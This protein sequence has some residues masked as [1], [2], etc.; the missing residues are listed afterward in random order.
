MSIDYSNIQQ[1]T[2]QM[3]TR[4]RNY[5]HFHLHI[6]TR[7]SLAFYEMAQVLTIMKAK[8]PILSAAMIALPHRVK[9]DS[10]MN[11]EHIIREIVE[12]FVDAATDQKRESDTKSLPSSTIVQILGELDRLQDMVHAMPYEIDILDPYWFKVGRDSLFGSETPTLLAYTITEGKEA[13]FEKYKG[14]LDDLQ[15]RGLIY[16]KPGTIKFTRLGSFVKYSKIFSYIQKTYPQ[17]FKVERKYVQPSGDIRKYRRGDRYT[18]LHV[19]RTLRNIVKK[20]KSTH[21]IMNEDLRMRELS[22]EKRCLV[23]LAIDHSWSMARSKKLHYAKEAVAGLVF[24]AKNNRDQTALI[25]F[26]DRARILSLPSKQYGQLLEKLTH[27]RPE[28]ET[29]I[30]DTLVK[31][32]KIMSSSTGNTLKHLIILTDGIPTSEI[33][34]VT[35]N[36]LESQILCESRKLKK[37]GV[38]ISV[39]C[40]RDEFEENDHSLAGKI[41]SIGKGTLSLMRTQDLLNQM[42]RGYANVKSGSI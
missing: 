28:N 25:A 6:G 22:K 11:H 20:R 33:D 24:A 23:L 12:S 15:Q 29:N 3:M 31:S 9:S 17:F 5:P 10:I 42:L 38:R 32:R 34:G 37:M 21:Q 8:D 14:L 19:K 1:I 39:V 13:D 36:Q 41:A 4:I 2:V 30:A 27:L 26:S 16:L 18:T 7:A 40:I 35:R